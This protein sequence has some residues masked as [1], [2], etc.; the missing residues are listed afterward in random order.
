METLSILQENCVHHWIIDTPEG[1]TSLGQCK[2]CGLAREF[3][4]IWTETFNEHQ[5]MPENNGAKRT[6]KVSTHV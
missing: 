3:C 5:V 6:D 2:K 1:P 4:N